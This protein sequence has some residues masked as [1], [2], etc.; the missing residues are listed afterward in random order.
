MTNDPAGV[1]GR[2]FEELEGEWHDRLTLD[3]ERILEFEDVSALAQL[4]RFWLEMCGDPNSL[5]IVDE[6][7]YKDV[8]SAETL[9]HIAWVDVSSENPL[10]FVVN[11]HPNLSSFPDMSHRKLRDHPSHAH[12]SSVAIEFLFAKR[13]QTV[14]YHQIEQTVGT[15]YRHYRRV[16][17]P[18]L[19]KKAGSVSR[20]VYAV[21]VIGGLS[22]S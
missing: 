8:L 19:D 15:M 16:M 6:F 17:V 14:S 7:L 5:P 12:S 20:I 10:D 11:D 2:D 4:Y 22:S 1:L 3:I 18:V 21:R 9:R 13:M